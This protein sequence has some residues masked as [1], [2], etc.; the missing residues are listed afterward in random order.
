[1]QQ[2]ITTTTTI[3]L[4]S[5]NFLIEKDKNKG[6]RAF[7]VVIVDGWV[8][9]GVGECQFAFAWQSKRTY[10]RYV[11]YACFPFL[12]PFRRGIERGLGSWVLGLAWGR[13]NN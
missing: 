4:T 6:D 13:L 7:V 3:T 11:P 8:A 1:M 5:P 12:A 10:V 9:R 2:T